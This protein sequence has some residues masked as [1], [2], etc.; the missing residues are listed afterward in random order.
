[1]DDVISNIIVISVTSAWAVT[2]PV[3]LARY[4]IPKARK[5]PSPISDAYAG[6]E[7]IPLKNAVVAAL[8][9]FVASRA[10]LAVFGLFSGIIASDPGRLNIFNWIKWDADHYLGLADNWYVNEG[11]ARF[12]IV[13]F[14]LYP[15]L[16]RAFVL[17]F[18]FDA[19]VV[20]IVVSNVCLIISAATMY[21]MAGEQYGERRGA[22]AARLFMLSPMTMFFSLPYS[23]SLFFM[24]TVL[25]VYM[26][27]RRKFALALAF[28]A[29][30]SASR[31]LG[32]L[33]AVGVFYEFIRDNRGFKA[34]DYVKYALVTCLASAGFLSYLALNLAVTG[35]AFTFLAYQREHWSQQMGSLANTLRYTLQNAA[36]Y[37]DEN[38]RLGT[39]IPQVAAIIVPVIL[40]ALTF[41]RVSPADGAYALLYIWFALSPTWLLSGA[42]YI[43]AMYP[44]YIMVASLPGGR[45]G[46][47][48]ACC[49]SAFLMFYMVHRF[50]SGG[51]M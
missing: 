33:A 19:R 8:L 38:I 51:V 35:D 44:L 9:S 23:E 14:P 2:L 49:A 22:A 10:L 6:A 25:A 5:A 48:V 28:A 15:A 30:A 29:L 36:D 18:G 7:P 4:F 41:R 39:W 26:A 13:F 3:L 37:S 32:L 1:M 47:I 12:H 42:R 34:R 20:G 40:L 11:D 43:S 50:L 46:E 31:L 45:K 21:K 17:A 27:R 16:I 24:L